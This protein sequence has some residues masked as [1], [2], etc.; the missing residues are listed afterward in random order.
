MPGHSFKHESAIIWRICTLQ[1]HDYLTCAICRVIKSRRA[2]QG[3]SG[4]RGGLVK[5]NPG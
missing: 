1:T 3:S 4:E 5:A 2:F